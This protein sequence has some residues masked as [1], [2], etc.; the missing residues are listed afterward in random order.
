MSFFINLFPEF[1][2]GPLLIE[3]SAAQK[4]LVPVSIQTR[5]IGGELL[6]D[7]ELVMMPLSEI[8]RI[9]KFFF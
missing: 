5:Y 9:L 8:Y 3:K 1:P 7:G 4:H 6:E 2:I